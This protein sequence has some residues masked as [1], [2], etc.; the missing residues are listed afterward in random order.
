MRSA[1]RAGST[2]TGP[3]L[4]TEALEQLLT[5]RGV[6][7]VPA[8][9]NPTSPAPTPLDTDETSSPPRADGELV[10]AEPWESRAFAMAVSLHDAGLFAWPQFQAALIA[11][12]AAWQDQ[13][14][15][16]EC[17]S[18]Y[19]QWLGALEDVLAGDGTVFT[20]E[21]VQRAAE[22]A[23]RPTGHGHPH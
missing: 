23:I 5:E 19:T 13:H 17:Y 7:H 11:R 2:P 21:V 6:A 1:A 10:F 9:E 16:G 8:S 20:D 12:I 4:R 15:E 18:Y 22:L 3:A 14:P